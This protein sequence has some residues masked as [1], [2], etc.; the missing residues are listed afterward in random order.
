ME[1]HPIPQN[2]TSFQ[3]KLIGDVTLKQFAYAASGVLI[4]YIAT[5]IT[6]I[7]EL[8]RWPVGV[9]ILLLGLGMAFV[10]IE[11]RP[12]DRWLLAFIKSIYSP[13]QFVYKKENRPPEIIESP[14]SLQP[15]P[16]TQTTTLRF[17]I[18]FRFPRKKK[19]I[20]TPS[21]IPHTVIAQ[22]PPVKP[23]PPPPP[24]PQPTPPQKEEKKFSVH[25]TWSLGAPPVKSNQPIFSPIQTPVT[26]KKVA[27]E[28]NPVIPAPAVSKHAVETK[29]NSIRA[30]YDQTT[31][32]LTDQI[33]SLQAELTKGT[34]ARERFLELQQVLTQLAVEKDRLSSELLRL[35]QQLEERDKGPAVKPVPYIPTPI[36]QKPVVKVVSPTSPVPTSIP[37][38][39]NSPNIITGIVKNSEGALL[40][41]LIVTVKDKEGMPVRALKTNKLGQFAASTPLTSNTYFIEIEDPKKT[42]QFNRIEATLNNQVLPPLEISAISEK[43]LMREKLSR[44]LFGK[45]TI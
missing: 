44:E 38:L 1:Q 39:T 30:S 12:L 40:P 24:P 11:E 37:R 4:G 22:P 13:T 26:G 23:K 29:M 35:K 27:F 16:T 17:N 25:D 6:L 19:L 41:N 5:K 43:D 18:P 20:V 14:K 2:V 31:H 45:N 42:Y 34:L 8:L 21:S 33:K 7:P 28:E 3:F 10:P 9:V 36:P 15:Q 32:V